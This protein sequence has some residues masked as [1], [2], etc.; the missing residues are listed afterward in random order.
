VSFIYVAGGFH[1]LFTEV[2]SFHYKTWVSGSGILV[3]AVFNIILN[4][5]FIPMYGQNAAGVTTMISGVII[6]FWMYYWS[7]RTEYIDVQFRKIVPLLAL[8]I[9]G[10]FVFNYSG[11]FAV[12]KLTSQEFLLKCTFC[13]AYIVLCFRVEEFKSNILNLLTRKKKPS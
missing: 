4:L 12:D 5:I 6:A 9:G 2:L 7:Q 8:A 1:R 11:Y 3:A 13:I 10:V